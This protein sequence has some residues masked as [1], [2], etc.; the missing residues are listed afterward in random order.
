MNKYYSLENI[1]KK[2]C[3]YNIIIGERSNGKTYAVEEKILI[4]FLKNGNEGA[5]IRR[6]AE[7]FKNKRG[8][9]MFAPFNDKISKMS[10]KKYNNILYRNK[11]FYLQKIDD[12][13]NVIDSVPFCYAFSLSEVE[14]DKSTNYPHITNILFD[15][16]LTRAFYLTDEFIIFC[17]CIST[18]IRDRNNAKIFM[19]GNTVNRYSP[20]FEE[21]GLKHIKNMTQ[22]TIDIYTYTSNLKVAVEYCDSTEKS[23]K[24]NIYFGFDNP[25]LQM[26]KNG[27]WEE[28]NYP[29]CPIKF[30][31]KDI[32][33]YFFCIFGDDVLQC[34]IVNIN[35]ELFVFVH[36][37]TSKIKN[38]NTDLIY[39]LKSNSCFNKR[40]SFMKPIDKIDKKIYNLYIS[41][42]F[43]YSDNSTGEIMNNFV[44]QGG[45]YEL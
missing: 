35:N 15:E 22:G 38:E 32:L 3:Q 26:I 42:K 13:K 7:D 2:D 27:K 24:S 21:M 18:I 1:L 17:N 43:F 41:N 23:K 6:W 44:K 37:K 45:N 11:T 28:L 20:Y 9:Q 4:D 16:F 8:N 5:I 33:L 10:H 31:P 39:N 29:H 36:K 14:H 34:E 19:C 12:E 30:K 40:F 25:R